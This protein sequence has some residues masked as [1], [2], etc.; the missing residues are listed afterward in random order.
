MLT[1]K[2]T[3]ALLRG[4]DDILVVCHASPDGDALGSM[5]GLVRG[6]RAM[7]KRAD[8]YC[9][10]PVPRKFTYMFEGLGDSPF[11]PV[12]VVTVDVADSKLLGNAEEKY[13]GGIELAI[14]HHSTHKPFA[15]ERWVDPQSPA[16]AGMV[17]SLLKELGISIDEAI[18]NC[19][20]T[21]M[22]T[23]TGCFRYRNT[24]PQILR[25]AAE[26]I[27][28]GARAGDI[29]QKIFETKS[30]AVLEA[31]RRLI[32]SMEF[33]CGGKGAVM[34]IP[35][36][37]YEATGAAEN[38]LSEL[39]GLPKQVEGVLVGVTL[40]EQA[41]GIVK[42]SLRTN[43]PVNAAAICEK[44]GGGGHPGGAGCTMEGMN[45]EEACERMK[46]ACEAYLAELEGK[47]G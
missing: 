12:H 41:G 18:A 24:S 46:A 1:C 34:R 15:A 30:R 38:E 10:D 37:L 44:F 4:W 11:P 36:S 19:L 16:T 33:F 45:M 29:N 9:A 13:G 21:G 32:E 27:E 40:K 2:E 35:F 17:W 23:D 7:G 6:L 47:H 28:A 26:A 42:A 5:T 3:T 25:L 14:D 22:A 39:V 20:Y 8:W 31:E 43:P